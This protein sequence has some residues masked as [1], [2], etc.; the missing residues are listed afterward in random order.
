MLWIPSSYCYEAHGFVPR[1]L[2][3]SHKYVTMYMKEL[4][5]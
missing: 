3:I 2:L 4:Y 5:A 1:H